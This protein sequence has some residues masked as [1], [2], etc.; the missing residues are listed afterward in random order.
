MKLT[1]SQLKQIIKEEL[2]ILEGYIPPTAGG[3]GVHLDYT[4]YEMDDMSTDH[5]MVVLLKAILGELQGLGQEDPNKFEWPKSSERE[6]EEVEEGNKAAKTVGDP[7]Y[8]ERGSTESQAQQ[9]A[10]GMALSA[11][12]GDTPVSKLK[13]A[14][15][16]LYKGEIST[17]DLRNLAKL[18]QKVKQH[19]SK[20][21]K[22][23]K[24][25]PGHVTP[26]KD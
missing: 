15:L 14:A 25:L 8:R 18:G 19:K 2:K 13:G 9:K 5:Q 24:S 6:P 7:P 16:D 10:A 1:K 3:G 4:D 23:L 11:R 12:R 26:A 17:K 21:P 22:H 20:E